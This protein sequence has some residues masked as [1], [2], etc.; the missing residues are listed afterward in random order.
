MTMFPDV[1]E[2]G[3]ANPC[4]TPDNLEY[5]IDHLGDGVEWEVWDCKKCFLSYT[6]AIE[7]VRDFDNISLINKRRNKHA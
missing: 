2:D 1:C 4:C 7:I 5:N 3:P 6:V